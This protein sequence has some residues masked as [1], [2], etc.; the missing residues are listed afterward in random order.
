MCGIAGFIDPD[1]CSY[2]EAERLT[3]RMMSKLRHRGPDSDGKWIELEHGLAFGHTRLAILDLSHAGAQPMHSLSGRYCI[4]FNGEIYNHSALRKVLLDKGLAFRGTSDTE[5]ILAGLDTWGLDETLDRV[6]GMFAFAVWDKLHHALTLCRD[7]LGEKPLYY[8]VAGKRVAFASELKA[9]LELPFVDRTIDY[10]ALASYLKYGYVPDSTCILRGVRKLPPATFLTVTRDSLSS[11]FGAS[12]SVDAGIEPVAYWNIADP[13]AT[14]M[15]TPYQDD[16]TAIDALDSILHNAVQEQSFADV[17]TGAFLSGGIDSTLVTAIMQAQSYGPVK[18]FTIG[19]DDP[20]FDEAPHAAR[21]AKH[22]GTDH[23]EEYV[24]AED[25]LALVPDLQ[26][27]FDEPFADSS[28]IPS[29]LVARRARHHVTVCLSGD[30]GDELFGG[31][32]R[33]NSTQR[34]WNKVRWL[35]TPVRRTIGTAGYRLPVVWLE[36]L[37]SKIRSGS[38]VQSLEKKVHKLADLVAGDN[39]EQIYDR[40][41]SYQRE[42]EQLLLRDFTL[43][44]RV[45]ESVWQDSSRP[46]LEQAM[47]FDMLQYL[48]GDNLAKV[49]RTSMSVGLETRLPLLS[50]GVVEFSRRIPVLMKVRNHQSKWILR[51]VLDR[52]VPRSL[53]QR[54]KMGFS[55]PI[56]DWIRGPLRSWTE[57]HLSRERIEDEEIFNPTAVHALL[58]DHLSGRRDNASVLWALMMFQ[59]WLDEYEFATT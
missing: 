44:V 31:Y 54:P 5:V 4:T 37:Q 16:Q 9:L 8:A 30:G 33:Y 47:L 40:L 36:L 58:N 15:N 45:W 6:S 27:I 28:Q 26:R 57:S 19:F 18:T 24:T 22:L 52:Y 34:I 48:P 43:D 25:A 51:Q 10:D 3:A 56:R 1:I 2:D 35:P 49:D 59:S 55:V 29:L 20:R 32:N 14:A 17:P 41:I 12:A 38:P 46:F 42:P 39:L 11:G 50:Q 7:R 23:V 53:V 13:V 21:I